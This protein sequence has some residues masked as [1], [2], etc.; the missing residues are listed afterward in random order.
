MLGGGAAQRWSPPGYEF[1]RQQW[2]TQRGA[3][4]AWGEE[5]EP[6]VQLQKDVEAVIAAFRKG[7]KKAGL[8]EAKQRGI[9]PAGRTYLKVRAYTEEELSVY[10][11][12]LRAKLKKRGK[13]RDKIAETIVAERLLR[14]REGQKNGHTPEQAV[15]D[16]PDVPRQGV[17]RWVPIT[18]LGL[19]V[20]SILLF[21]GSMWARSQ[22]R[23]R[24]RG[25]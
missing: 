15:A 12:R 3:W 6:E 14:V 18:G 4:G 21:G 7:G 25:A 1:Y 23:R 9:E 24:G 13:L 20:V 22:R 10:L 11:A 19:S 17:P 16:L 8:R 2:N 5:E